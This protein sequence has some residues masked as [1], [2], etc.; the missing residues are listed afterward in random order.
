MTGRYGEI[1]SADFVS[2]AMAGKWMPYNDRKG[3]YIKM[4]GV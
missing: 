1:A 3:G 2:L 4:T